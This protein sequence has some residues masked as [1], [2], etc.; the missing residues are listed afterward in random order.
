L[1]RDAASIGLDVP[2]A[3]TNADMTYVQMKQYASFL[4]KELLFPGSPYLAATAPTPGARDAQRR[5]FDAM[6]AAGIRPDFIY[7]VAWDP[8]LIA[9]EALRKVGPSASADQLRTFIE[10]LHGFNGILGEYDFRD[11]SQRGLTEGNVMMMRWDSTKE[12]WVAVS[13]LGGQPL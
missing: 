8:A 9:V 12:T 7:S 3:A 1:L 4:P 10:N 11:G 6:S 2:I 13:R 5:F